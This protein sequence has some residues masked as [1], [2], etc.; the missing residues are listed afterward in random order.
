MTA[1]QALNHA[2]LKAEVLKKDEPKLD[3]KIIQLLRG[4]RGVYSLKR[5]AMKII[6]NLC[7]E[8]EIKNIRFN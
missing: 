5:E 7:T 6:V 2:W 1:D 3:P 4:F 8:N